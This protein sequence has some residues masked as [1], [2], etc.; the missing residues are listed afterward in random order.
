MENMNY[1][2]TEYEL[3]GNQ[4]ETNDISR[5]HKEEGEFNTHRKLKA[6]VS[7]INKDNL[8]TFE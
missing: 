3:Q 8:N 7:E 4:K 1:K 2:R 5:R 6:S